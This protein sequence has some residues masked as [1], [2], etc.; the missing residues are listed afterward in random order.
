MLDRTFLDWPFLEPRHREIAAEIE[1]WA[2]ANIPAARDAADEDAACR[3]LVSALG[4]DG[5]LRYVVGDAPDDGGGIEVRSLCLI[6]ETLARHWG[7]ADFAFA[8]QGLGSCPI[9]L[10]GSAELKSKYLGAVSEG[11]CVTAFALSEKDAGS[12][13][14]ATALAAVR[15]G[16]DFF[17]DGEKTW[18]SNAG[19][20][21]MYVVFARTGEAPGAKGL[22]AFAVD[23]DTPGLEVS[24]RIVTTSPHPLGTLRLSACRVGARQRL[25]DGGDGFEIAMATLDV[26]RT[27]VGAAALGFSRRA[28]QQSARR[29]RE[30][31]VFDQP[32]S[33]FQ[34]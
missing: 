9:S 2:L 17:L 33:D 19:I 16:D 24:E 10:Y 21:D 27:T 6:R 12:N 7:L 1:E 13:V 32:L 11:T 22:S 14:A 15:D 8:M 26:F 18:I 25:G 20:A 3:A 23:A 5:W 31:K 30:R 28:L 29:V 34:M 4:R